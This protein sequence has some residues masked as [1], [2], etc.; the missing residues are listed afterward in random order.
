[1]H[2]RR[3][4]VQCSVL[5]LLIASVALAQDSA[6]LGARLDWVPISGAERNDVS[7]SGFVTA[8]LSRSR[9]SITGCFEGLPAAALRASLHQGIATGA[10]GP[11]FAELTVEPAAAGTLSGAI[12]LSRAQ[13]DALLAGQLYV[14]LHAER[15]VAPDNAV[16]WGFLLT[17]QSTSPCTAAR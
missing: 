6:T 15:G 1:M 13:R 17:S 12:D 3:T 16:L 4:L 7:G 11:A 10:R 8:T 5:A 2:A 14:Q 9:L